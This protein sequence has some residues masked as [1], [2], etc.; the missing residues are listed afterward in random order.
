MTRLMKRAILIE[1]IISLILIVICLLVALLT[2]LNLYLAEKDQDLLV[3]NT[4]LKFLL[5][6]IADLL[7]WITG[8]LTLTY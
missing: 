8:L 3:K 5:I 1:W 2:N 6:T 7:F 4:I